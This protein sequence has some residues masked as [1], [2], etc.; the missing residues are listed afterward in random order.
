[1]EIDF[2]VMMS[3][4]VF[5]EQMLGQLMMVCGIYLLIVGF[6]GMKVYDMVVNVVGQVEMIMQQSGDM[7]VCFG[8]IDVWQVNELQEVQDFFVVLMQSFDMFEWVQ[9]LDGNLWV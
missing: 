9:V 8:C 7:C 2:G 5:V 1:M 4:I 3:C 6:D